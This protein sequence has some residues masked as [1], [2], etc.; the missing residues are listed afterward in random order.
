M[1][2]RVWFGSDCEWFHPSAVADSQS[3]SG[4]ID[5]VAWR[6][7]SFQKHWRDY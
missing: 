6:P 7:V 3:F 1:K 5:E 4:S 2:K